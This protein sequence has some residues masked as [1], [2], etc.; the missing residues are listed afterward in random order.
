[1]QHNNYDEV[2]KDIEG[3]EGQYQISNY[4][5]VYSTPKDGK[6]PKI[7]KQGVEGKFRKTDTINSYRSVRFSKNGKT[8]K[9]SVHRLVAKA[10]VQNPENKPFVNHIDS[11]PSNNKANNLEWCTH[12]ENMLHCVKE[13]RHPGKANGTKTNRP[14]SEAKI[15]AHLGSLFISLE[16]KDTPGKTRMYTTFTCSVCG[17]E[18]TKRPD[19]PTL[20][21][22]VCSRTCTNKLK[23]EDMPDETH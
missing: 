21:N 11:K 8:E 20:K 3:Y 15:K 9:F 12:S 17:N 13:G 23:L 10:F 22:K 7:L 16:Y 19:S 5:N 1:M 18:T 4:G 2:Y 14:R 6:K